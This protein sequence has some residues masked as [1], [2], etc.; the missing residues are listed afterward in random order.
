[1]TKITVKFL[2]LTAFL[3]TSNLYAVNDTI[4]TKSRLKLATYNI[5]NFGSREISSPEKYTDTPEEYYL[6]KELLEN[7]AHLTAVQEV[8]D[9]NQFHGFI[10]SNFYNYESILSNCGGAG[11]QKLGFIYDSSEL[12]LI[13]YWEDDSLKEKE[14]CN[15][16]LRPAFI[17]KFYHLKLKRYFTAI[18]IHLKAGGFPQNIEIREKQYDLLSKIIRKLKSKGSRNFIIMGD[19]N[20]TE[21]LSRNRHHFSFKDFVSNNNLIDYSSNLDCTSYWNG[22][23]DDGFFTAS[24]LD[25]ILVSESVDQMFKQFTTSIGAHCLKNRCR[26]STEFDL[27][28][29]FKEVSDHC[30]VHVNLK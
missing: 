20:T 13:K 5:R 30:P 18:S 1:M 24:L 15:K 8:K 21:Y 6:K 10:K 3:L 9:A 25:H 29:T 26:E 22:G 7:K 14:E 4:T 12:M 27:G 2:C 28:K 17:A 23:E 16:G 11:D 19:F